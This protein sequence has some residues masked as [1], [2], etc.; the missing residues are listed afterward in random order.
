MRQMRHCFC[1]GAELGFYRAHDPLDHCGKLVCQQAAY[2]A[3]QELRR[4][5]INRIN[6]HSEEQ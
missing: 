2:K 4:I 6:Q 1:C 3:V 5:A